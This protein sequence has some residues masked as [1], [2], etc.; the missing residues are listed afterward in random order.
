MALLSVEDISEITSRNPKFCHIK[1][2][3]FT[4]DF[5][6]T[7]VDVCDER[8]ATALANSGKTPSCPICGRKTVCTL[9]EV[10][11]PENLNII[12]DVMWR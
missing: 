3:T 11:T 8:I 5:C 7:S 9:Y 2:A 6:T 12:K 1:R 4:C 10:C